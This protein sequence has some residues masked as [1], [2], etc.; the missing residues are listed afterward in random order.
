VTTVGLAGERVLAV[1]LLVVYGVAGLVTYGAEG[2]LQHMMEMGWLWGLCVTVGMIS[3]CFADACTTAGL[4]FLSPITWRE[5]YSPLP[6]DTGG[7]FE[8]VVIKWI[9]LI[10]MAYLGWV[11]VL[12]WL[13]LVA[14]DG[15]PVVAELAR[16]LRDL[17]ES[18][19]SGFSRA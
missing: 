10:L 9:L 8:K 7:F 3:H 14:P 11:V 6:F 18:V 17:V 12:Q 13:P 5:Y 19:V 15:V 4:A 1:P 16:V 2:F